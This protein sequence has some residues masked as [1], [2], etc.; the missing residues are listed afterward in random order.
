MTTRKLIQTEEP[1]RIFVQIRFHHCD[2][3]ENIFAD[4]T[5]LILNKEVETFSDDYHKESQMNCYY[6]LMHLKLMK[7]IH[8]KL[9]TNLK[10][11]DNSN[12]YLEKNGCVTIISSCNIVLEITNLGSL[13][14]S[15]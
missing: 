4:S 15:N 7:L 11:L 9:L 12:N 13:D 1:F 2:Q 8:L 10:L 6:R 14:Q 3:I 5:R